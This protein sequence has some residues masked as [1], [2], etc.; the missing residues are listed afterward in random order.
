[1]EEMGQVQTTWNVALVG[2]DEG[3]MV[4]VLGVAMSA[5]MGVVDMFTP[6]LHR[7]TRWRQALC[8]DDPSNK[9]QLYGKRPAYL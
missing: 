2:E 1:M 3:A 6:Y 4:V 9:K 7:R 8:T 5:S